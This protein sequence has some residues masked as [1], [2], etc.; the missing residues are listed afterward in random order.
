MASSTDGGSD[1][2][3]VEVAPEHLAPRLQDLTDKPAEPKP[4]ATLKA[5]A[6]SGRLPWF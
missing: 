4:P 2:E 6:N 3:F 1:D 5:L